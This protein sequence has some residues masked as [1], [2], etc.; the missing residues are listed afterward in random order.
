MP[1]T[2]VD[3]GIVGLLLLAGHVGYNRGLS[4][5]LWSTLRWWL[6]VI[7]GAL[8]CIPLG[9]WLVGLV[10]LQ[11]AVGMAVAYSVLALSIS[12][13]VEQFHRR[14]G[15]RL[16]ATAPWGSGDSYLGIAAGV[17]AWSAAL[18]FALALLNPIPATTPD[19]DPGKM[20]GSE[21]IEALIQ[22][23]LG[24]LRRLVLDESF[25]GKAAQTYLSGLLVP[26]R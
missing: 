6:V 8:A 23:V 12:L 16:A 25:F 11:P 3:A 9:A 24:S 14:F 5:M 21:A 17:L 26:A 15:D 4:E 13:L 7:G 18:I 19:W 20:S 22:V 10:R 2:P 1:L